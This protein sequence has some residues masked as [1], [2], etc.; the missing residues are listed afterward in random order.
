MNPLN[1]YLSY[2]KGNA[3]LDEHS[4]PGIKSD[5]RRRDP[6]KA[7]V[8]CMDKLDFLAYNDANE[9]LYLGALDADGKDLP[10]D[11]LKQA[12]FAACKRKGFIVKHLWFAA[13]DELE[14][15]DD[16]YQTGFF[17]DSVDVFEMQAMDSFAT[18]GDLVNTSMLLNR[19]SECTLDTWLHLPIGSDFPEE[20]KG[21]IEWQLEN[22]DSTP[23]SVCGIAS[24]GKTH[25]M[26]GVAR[27]FAEMYPE[28]AV[29]YHSF[30]RTVKELER[31]WDEPGYEPYHN[32]LGS[33]KKADILFVDDFVSLNCPDD[34]N[35]KPREDLL[36]AIREC[37]EA[38]K[39]VIFAK[40]I[41]PRYLR[42]SWLNDEMLLSTL[43]LSLRNHEVSALILP[44]LSREQRM[45][46]LLHKI[47][48]KNMW[49]SV[50]QFRAL[51]HIVEY[52]I[53]FG[54][55]LAGMMKLFR[56]YSNNFIVDVDEGMVEKAVSEVYSRRFE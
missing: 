11:Q 7:I 43:K 49:L 37:V 47:A 5:L 27:Y 50:S 36:V 54:Y 13:P 48:L 26:Y 52:Q 2:S 29:L 16:L 53:P 31:L 35:L 34:Q 20:L 23:I 32:K 46:V 33:L 25:L 19:Y 17:A 8:S 15:P 1:K 51:K 3:V 10:H 56:E 39:L 40:T 18:S 6:G 21:L 41:S 55:E 9:T 45:N 28:G 14:P 12:I 44:Y 22:G 38:K 4:W 42:P 24:S 30:G